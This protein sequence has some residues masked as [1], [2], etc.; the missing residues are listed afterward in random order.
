LDR[1]DDELGAGVEPDPHQAVSNRDDLPEFRRPIARCG[2]LDAVAALAGSA[3]SPTKPRFPNHSQVRKL[4]AAARPNARPVFELAASTGLRRGELFALRWRDIDFEERQIRVVD[5]KTK[6]GER[7]VPMFPSARKVLLE[8]KA[9]SR[10]KR[11]EDLVFCTSVGTPIS[12]NSWMMTE[13]YSAMK[14]AGMEHAFRFHDLRH[15]AVSCLIQQ[16]AHVLLVSRVAG[17][18]QPSITL[19]VYGHLFDEDLARAAREYDPL[20]GAASE[21]PPERRRDSG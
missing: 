16:G 17:H 12:A 14:R 3:R 7:V 11:P 19:D 21:A 2:D 15:Y 4:I 9:S 18:S 20:R 13:F 8:H 1:I 10:F 5:S 6:A